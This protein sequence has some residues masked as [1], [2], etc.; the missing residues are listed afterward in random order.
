[1]SLN[2]QPDFIHVHNIRFRIF[3][4]P[5][6]KTQKKAYPVKDTLYVLIN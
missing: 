5:K 6:Y 3:N 4:T 1:M 2:Q